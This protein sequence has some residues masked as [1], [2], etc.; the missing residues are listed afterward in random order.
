MDPCH[1]IREADEV[2]AEAGEARD[3][4]GLRRTLLKF[5]RDLEQMAARARGLHV[6]PRS[7]L[8][9]RCEVAGPLAASKFLFGTRISSFAP[10]FRQRS[11]VAPAERFRRADP[12]QED[13]CSNLPP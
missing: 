9:P 6:A 8:S 7:P 3:N 1:Y 5:A 11:F 4:P 12:C 10:L 2:R 13:R